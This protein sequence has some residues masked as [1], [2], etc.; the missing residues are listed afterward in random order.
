MNGMVCLCLTS[1]VLS[2]YSWAECH[3]VIQNQNQNNFSGCTQYWEIASANKRVLSLPNVV[4]L[5]SFI[6]HGWPYLFKKS[7]RI[8]CKPQN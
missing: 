2:I 4:G 3:I 6:Q 1:V 7:Q 8:D 5:C